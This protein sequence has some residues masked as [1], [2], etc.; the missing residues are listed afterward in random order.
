MTMSSTLHV[1][2]VV[3]IV[4][5]IGSECFLFENGNRNVA[6]KLYTRS[7]TKGRVIDAR[8]LFNSNFNNK[9]QTKLIIHGWFG[10]LPKFDAMITELLGKENMNVIQVNW[11]NWSS[12]LDYFQVVEEVPEVA[13]EVKRFMDTLIQDGGLSLKYVHLI[14]Y[15]LGAQIA[16]L[17]GKKYRNPRIPRISCLDPSGVGF[18]NNNPM[19]SVH[20]S[21]A[22]FVDVIHSSIISA[23]P[24][25]DVD[26]F[27]NNGMGS[28]SLA[29]KL[30]E[31]SIR[32][33]C[34]FTARSCSDWDAFQSKRCDD[35][36]SNVMGL[37]A[38]PTNAMGK[39]YLNVKTEAPFC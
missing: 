22:V 19:A 16:S 30:F 9:L 32:R 37:D 26:F 18:D 24:R 15:S 3:L 31:E 27:P 5:L 34:D 38:K 13:A 28:H 7:D 20:K 2:F 1:A 6:F 11:S 36:A 4:K 29:L 14:G 8:T 17:V 35:N 12:N 39:L 10:D 33:R 25:G 23:A 21:D